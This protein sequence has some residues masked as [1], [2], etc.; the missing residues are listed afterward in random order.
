MV[1]VQRSRQDLLRRLADGSEPNLVVDEE[2][3]FY[4]RAVVRVVEVDADGVALEDAVADAEDG[5]AGHEDAAVLVL[6]EV[7]PA[8]DAAVEVR[9][10]V[11]RR[12]PA[13]AV[14]L[15]AAVDDLAAAAVLQADAPAVGVVGEGAPD[16][17]R[18]RPGLDE[19]ARRRRR[20]VLHL[21]LGREQ[22]RRGGR[23]KNAGAVVIVG[24]VVVGVT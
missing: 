8:H 12:E 7:D 18:V 10:L 21:V 3:L 17:A 9:R 4:F 14:A 5:A 19:Q 13:E 22:R 16:E 15:D 20:R 23:N 2:A 1:N 24:G 11:H 6:A